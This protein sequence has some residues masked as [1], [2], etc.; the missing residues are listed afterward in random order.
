M[1]SLRR[2]KHANSHA[3]GAA[4]R[5]VQSEDDSVQ[6][7]DRF[8]QVA[9]RSVHATTHSVQPANDQWHANHR[10]A[11]RSKRCRAARE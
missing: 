9:G 10:P 3:G 6:R 4:D 2:Q 5:S 11:Q 7:P 1:Q 8:V